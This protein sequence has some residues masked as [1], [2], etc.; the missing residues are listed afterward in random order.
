MIERL[1]TRGSIPELAMRRCVLKEFISCLFSIGA[2]QTKDM[3]T[4]PKQSD[5][6]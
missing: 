4:E 5:L 6:R 3:Q 2:K 1:L